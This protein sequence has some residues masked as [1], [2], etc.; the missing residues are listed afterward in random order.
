M[1]GK[2]KYQH[3]R[4]FF[5]VWT[6][7]M[8][9]LVGFIAADGCIYEHKHKVTKAVTGRTLHIELQTQDRHHLEKIRSLL[10][11]TNQ[12]EYRK[13]FHSKLQNYYESYILRIFSNDLC[14]DLIDI[15]LR[16]RK[17][18]DLQ[19]IEQCPKELVPHLV[20]GYVDGDGCLRITTPTKRGL[21]CSMVGTYDF[22][23]GIAKQFDITHN[24]CL[25]HNKTWKLNYGGSNAIK[26]CNIIYQNSYELIRLDR[27]YNT[28]LQGLENYNSLQG[29]SEKYSQFRGVKRGYTRSGEIRFD[30][31][32]GKKHIRRYKTELE[33]ALAYNNYV[34]ENNIDKPLNII[35]TDNHFDANHP[36]ISNNASPDSDP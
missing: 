9:Y 14:N 19:W 13:A 23:H 5:K 29:R 7:A 17:T 4:N 10:E 12:I 24:I 32:C 25:S 36:L 21:N 11:S 16:P 33:A 35:P 3:N 1:A 30:A 34:L 15:G 8:A 18:W 26:F 20:R 22:I 27:K 6:P 28:Y 31:F 2:A